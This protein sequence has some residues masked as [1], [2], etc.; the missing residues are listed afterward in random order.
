[1]NIITYNV[2][3]LGRGVKWVS[4]RRLIKKESIDMICIQ[5]TKKETI[6]KS[7]CQAIWRDPVV[8]WEMQLAIN[9]ARGLLCMW[10]DKKI[11]IRKEGYQKWVHL[12]DWAVG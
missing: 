9:S 5:E 1:M 2:R 3:G 11:E 4:I 7:L 10:C 12:A 8:S 6:E